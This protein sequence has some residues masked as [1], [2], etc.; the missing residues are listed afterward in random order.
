MS[1]AKTYDIVTV[2]GATQ[3][4][5]V[6]S[7]LSKILRMKDM[8]SESEYMCFSYGSKLNVD[9][10]FF[11]IGGGALNTA[12]NFANLGFKVAPVVKIGQDSSGEEILKRI[13]ERGVHKELVHISNEC[14]TG[15]SVILNSF[16][17][18][19]T[20]LTYRGANSRMRIDDINWEAIKKSKWIY[21]SSLSGDS[22]SILDSLSDFAEE[23]GVNMAFNPGSTQIKRGMDGL[24]RVLEQTEFL[25]LNKEEAEHLTGIKEDFRYID[26]DKCTGCKTCVD[27]CPAD[28]YRID[29]QGKAIHHGKKETCVKGCEIC[30]THCP[31]LAISVSPW[32]SNIDEQLTKL[33]SF[34]PKVVVITDGN[35]GVQVYDGKYRYLMASYKVPVKSTLGAGDC[36]AS[37]FTAAMINTNWDIIKS[38]KY[39]AANAANIV[40]EYGAQKG[41]KKFDELDKFIEEQ[42]QA[43]EE[44]NH[45][46]R[47]ELE[48]NFNKHV[49]SQS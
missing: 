21:I 24:K 20:V 18:E 34:G 29:D 39:A 27:L 14:K 42:S 8:F 48:N 28:I 35:K 26:R 31:E 37:T 13:S 44:I 30:V 10:I 49:I 40:Q 25:I 38:V 2:G 32:A 11:G 23:H 46:A 5:F 43:S 3:D 33:K 41:F 12:T 16:E 9:E 4:V 47:K 15:F 1:N 22:N 36:F 19:R 6:R 45:V 7:D 17:G